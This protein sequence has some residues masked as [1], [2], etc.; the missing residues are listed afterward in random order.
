MQRA[1]EIAA[2]MSIEEK[3]VLVNGFRFAESAEFLKYGLKHIQF[4]DGGTGLNFEQL[5]GDLLSRDDEYK[6]YM[7]TSVFKNVRMNFYMPEKLVSDEEKNLHKW[8]TGKLSE[9]CR[10]ECFS[11]TCFPDGNI[12]GATWN[13]EIVKNVGSALG[14]EASAYGVTNLLGTPY[15][16]LLRDPR[17]GR[18]FEGWSEDPY[19]EKSLAPEITKG[20]QEAGVGANVKHFAANNQETF[21]V[22]ID[23]TISKRA[24]EE[25]YLPAFKACV[26]SGAATVMSAYNSINRVRCTENKELLTNK[27]REEWGFDGMVESDWGAVLDDAA[28]INAGNDIAMPGFRSNEEIMKG[29][30][31][32]SISE[33][34]LDK[35]AKR[36]IRFMLKYDADNSIISRI[37]ER[38]KKKYET[39]NISD[40][41]EDDKC[42]NCEMES[43]ASYVRKRAAAKNPLKNI[44]ESILSESEEA[45]YHAALEGIVL[46]KN[47]KTKYGT[48]FPLKRTGSTA[49]FGAGA[50][51]FFECGTGSA[52]ITTD[53]TTSLL[54]E[55]DKRLN[56]RAVF[57][58]IDADTKN[59]IFV[60]RVNGMEG[61]DR[62][63]LCLDKEEEEKFLDII[64]YV[65]HAN[66]SNKKYDEQ[67]ESVNAECTSGIKIGVILNVCGPVD[68][69][70]WIDDVDS[71]LCCFLPGSYGA[72]AAAAILTGEETPSGRLPY[73]FPLR[74]EDTPA[75]LNFPGAGKHVY[76]GED[77]FVGYRWYNTRKIKP[78]FP[79]G[80][81]LS[82]T[83]FDY[84]NMEVSTDK[85]DVTIDFD[86]V[87]I[88]EYSGAE[89]AELYIKDEKSRYM[90]PE[91]ELKRFKKVF[92]RPGEMGHV[93]FS[94]EKQDFA[95]YDEDLNKFVA[96]E[97]T[98]ELILASSAMPEDEIKKVIFTA[99]WNSEYSYGLDTP[100]FILHDDAAAFDAI[101]DVLKRYNIDAG[102][103]DDAYEYN[104]YETVRE[105]FDADKAEIKDKMAEIQKYAEM[106]LVSF[107]RDC[108]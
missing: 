87:N 89:T 90:R 77:I 83:C 99:E 79:F 7:A 71:V 81:G 10:V 37:A 68:C 73:T 65:K 66:E 1:A 8:L 40:K 96:E 67:A 31:E 36:I 57:E 105:F 106:K 54:T 70:K 85:E 52:G 26:E 53:R 39:L 11:P 35:A 13:P 48:M 63:D 93:T 27:L 59:V 6:K 64:K 50:K 102:K 2:E 75:Y 5:L 44:A 103:L 61:N 18:H 80:F 86:I 84:S 92:L 3:S 32:K 19:L 95:V 23:E 34:T 4:L 22:G 14:K 74:L 30:R 94:L 69:R 25:L 46:L 47:K 62:K 56:G 42:N 76:Y 17:S 108:R 28:A 82:Y 33:E 49:L 98:Y 78:L 72:A 12:M 9:Q 29:I 41:P 101:Y 45:A 107:Q 15:V 91:R 58:T 88:G 38:T 43:A 16:N 104:S 97:G 100:L 55:L 21:R 24:M 51:K 60:F 20:V